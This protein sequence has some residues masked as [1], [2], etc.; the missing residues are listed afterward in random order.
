MHST[1]HAL[2]ELSYKASRES[3]RLFL[4]FA[5][6]TIAYVFTVDALHVPT[7]IIAIGLLYFYDLTLRK[8]G[9]IL[10][11]KLAI[12]ETDYRELGIHESPG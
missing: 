7:A 10:A 4:F 11:P 1:R 2:G 9:L 12:P 5:L 8:L 3:R 6:P